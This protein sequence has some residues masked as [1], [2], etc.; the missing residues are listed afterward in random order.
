VLT[1]A[2][3]NLLPSAVGVAISPVPIIAVILMLGTPKAKS[4]GTAFAAGWVA[5][6]VI[7]S[8]IVLLVTDTASDP[9]S[10]AA[11]SV[12]WG[13][14]AF[15]ALFLVLAV[16]QWR[17]RPQGDAETEMPKWMA[18]IDTFSAGKALGLGAVL[19]GVN[20]KNLALTAAAAASIAQAG[21][22]GCDAAIAAGVFV[23]VASLTVVGP[24][25]FSLVARDAAAGPLA[26][27]KDFLSEHNSAI[28]ITVLAVLGV[29]L[30]GQGLGA[31]LG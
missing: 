26:S 23:A 31:A 15:G 9:D 25:A 22:G 7:V 6:L 19:S 2:I 21:I 16:R 5:G 13:Q 11:A 4:T 8:A 30:L 17:S 27:L 10:A 12:N 28:M 29:K 18:A 1:E 20:P 24:V 3:G 14:V